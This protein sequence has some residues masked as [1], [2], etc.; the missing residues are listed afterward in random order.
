MFDRI[1]A[2][3]SSLTAGL[4][5]R[6]L[7]D[8]ELDELLGQFEVSLLESDVAR[9]V[10]ANIIS[11]LKEDLAGLRIHRSVDSRSYVRTKLSESIRALIANKATPN[12][13]E[14]I[15]SKRSSGEPFVIVFLGINGTG[16][17][18]T[19]AKF[20]QMLKNHGYSVVLACADTHRA[21]AIEQLAEHA[22]RLSVKIVS[23]KYGA[24]PAAVARDA[25][26]HAR[27]Q[28]LDV[29]LV[30]TA[31]RMQTYRN[32]MEEMS[33]IVRVAKPDLKIFVGDALAGNDAVSQAKEFL[34]FTDFDG[35][36]LTKSDADVKGGAALS[37]AYATG[38]PILFLGVG[39][40]YQDLVPFDP[41]VFL[42]SL[43]SEA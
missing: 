17:T 32:L 7:G 19:I 3:L 11:K 5:Q 4:T 12:V 30:D 33:K 21:G 31:G 25:V 8:E 37:I 27:T 42:D 10:V 39:Q 14:L 15:K 41:D 28:H 38:K 1:K 35:A 29:V 9:E 6:T 20:A 23:Q 22:S 24:D 16:K 36:I 40:T 2:A 43:F 34:S 18:T 26:L 13:L